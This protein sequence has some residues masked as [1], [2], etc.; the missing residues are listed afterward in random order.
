MLILSLTSEECLEVLA[1]L[2][3]GRLGCSRDN[4]PY[5]VPTHFTYHEGHLYSFATFGQKIEWMRANPLVCIEADEIVDHYRWTSVIVQ[6][7]YE[8]LLDTP[9]WRP[10][11]ELAHALLQ[12]RA[13]WW[14]P[15]YVR[16]AH[17]VAAGSL[18]PIYY[19]VQIDHVTGRRAGPDPVEAVTL[20]EPALV[21]TSEGWLKSLLRRTRLIGPG[22]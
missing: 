1:R 10:E 18:I 2:R 22:Q 9:T 11:R 8:E 6:G 12:G 7:R 20:V 4:R 19:R 17:L 16:T 21:P 5:I 13:A 15:A 3:F 14:E